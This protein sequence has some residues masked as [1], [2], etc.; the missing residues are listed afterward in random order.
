MA[1][2]EQWRDSSLGG[3][4]YI[5]ALQ[6]GESAC[7]FLASQ[8]REMRFILLIMIEGLASAISVTNCIIMVLNVIKVLTVHNLSEMK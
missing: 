5:S 4:T 8:I 7:L 6:H 1:H 3:K 2:V